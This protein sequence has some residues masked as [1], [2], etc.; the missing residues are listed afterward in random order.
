MTQFRVKTPAYVPGFLNAMDKF[1][2]EDFQSAFANSNYP[3]VNISEVEN[4]YQITMMAPGLNKSD[5]K[6]ALEDNILTIS[7]EKQEEKSEETPKYIRKEF[8]MKSFKRSFTLNENLN[9]EAITA[10]YENGLLTLTIPKLEEK[11]DEAKVK[12]INVN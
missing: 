11:V 6:V 4:A 9:A 12:T 8:S 5:F 1:F 2:S 3:A 7:Y 10:T